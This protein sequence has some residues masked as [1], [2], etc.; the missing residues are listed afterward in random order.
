MSSKWS[1]FPESHHTH[2]R[3]T[4]NGWVVRRLFVI[5]VWQR[6]SSTSSCKYGKQHYSAIN[7]MRT[8]LP[9]ELFCIHTYEWQTLLL[10]C[11]NLISLWDGV[12][13]RWWHF[14]AYSYARILTC[15][16]DSHELTFEYTFIKIIFFLLV[17]LCCYV[18]V[19]CSLGCFSFYLLGFAPL[20]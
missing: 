15:Q 4:T 6:R 13:M 16:D 17:Y 11:L 10:L 2:R 3:D 8:R 1:K 9:K 20:G 7:L 18:Y 14:N 19:G 12:G 5:R